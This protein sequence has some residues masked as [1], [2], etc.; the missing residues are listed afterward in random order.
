[1][2]IAERTVLGVAE[3]QSIARLARGEAARDLQVPHADSLET[4]VPHKLGSSA[5]QT[6]HL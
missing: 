2:E 6:S 3:H 5:K 4:V 1:M